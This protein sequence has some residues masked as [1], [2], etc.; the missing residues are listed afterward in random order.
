[1]GHARRFDIG[2]TTTPAAGPG[3]LI[4]QMNPSELIR[5][6]SETRGEP[7]VG[8]R[9]IGYWA[10]E[11]ETIPPSWKAA[12]RYVDEVWTPSSFCAEAIGRSA[13]RGLPIKVVPHRAPVNE[14]APARERF[15]LPL[16]HVIVLCAFDL[17]STLARKNP[18]GALE[19]FRRAT[20]TTRY[21]ATLV[22]K[23]VGGADAPESLA[24]LRAAIGDAADVVLLTESLDIEARDQLM[25]SCD[26]FLSLHRS[27]GF[28]LLLAEAMAAGKAVV[29]TGWSANMDFMDS[30]SSVLIPFTL[31]PVDDPQGLY[32][33]G[34]WADA[35]RT[36]AGKA[37]A[38][39]INDPD[40]RVALGVKARTAITE[41]LGP[42]VIAQLMRRAFDNNSETPA[43]L[44]Q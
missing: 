36:A 1:M 14:A 31:F 4:T 27:E 25:A 41:R 2:D 7:F 39:L 18:F 40:Y 17:R 22:F 42:S 21:P 15:G 32:Q 13:P 26:I 9:S 23:T 29:A 16:D 11:L 34:V 6:V 37:L 19:A 12:F 8:K 38:E 44:V 3:V 24:M 30:D 5:L 35:D 33:K 28:G 10:W 20:A 43:D